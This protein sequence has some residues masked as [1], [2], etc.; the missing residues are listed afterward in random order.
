MEITLEKIELVKDRTGVSY[1]EAKEALE[2][3]D[4]SVVDAIIAIEETIDVNKNAKRSAFAED[5]VNRIKELVKKGN[6]SKIAIKRED[7][8]LLNIPVNVGIIGVVIAPWGILFAA[9]VAYGYNCKI[10]L[11]TDEG[12]VIDITEKADGVVTTVKEKGSVVVDE[13]MAKGATVINDV[14]EKAPEAWENLKEKAPEAWENLKEKA[15]EAWETVKE[16]S[17]ETFYNIKD[18]ATEKYYEMKNKKND[19]FDE[20][21][22]DIMDDDADAEDVDDFEVEVHIDADLSTDEGVK[23]ASDK[24]EVAFDEAEEAFDEVEEGTNKFRLFHRDK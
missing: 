3:T 20:I 17:T 1:K 24:I 8:V 4:G 2:A 16:K 11:T 5:T 23:E 6:I 22:D 7:E 12:K 15:P 14:K 13:V 9:L 19:G 10:E 18:A 21:F